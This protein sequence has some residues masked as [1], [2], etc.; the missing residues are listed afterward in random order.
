MI[1]Q[2]I[3]HNNLN[4]PHHVSNMIS[5]LGCVCVYVCARVAGLF[6]NETAPR[7]FQLELGDSDRLLHIYVNLYYHTVIYT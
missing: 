2:I 5:Q 1:S 7:K 4:N 3:Y 6:A